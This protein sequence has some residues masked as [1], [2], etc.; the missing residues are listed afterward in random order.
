MPEPLETIVISP[1]GRHDSTVIWMH[2][3]GADGSDFLPIVPQLGLPSDN[4]IRFIFPNAPLRPITIN[5]GMTM[6]GW[7]DIV[8]LS[9]GVQPDADGIV[10]S[11][12]AIADLVQQERTAG[13]PSNRIMLAGFSQ[14]GAIALHCGP[15]YTVPLA[16]IC[17]LS[18][19]L[20][21]AD[22]LA[23]E[24]HLC[25]LDTPIFLAHGKEDPLISISAGESCRDHLQQR[26]YQVEWRAYAMAHAAFHDEL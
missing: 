3:L 6:R 26:G 5:Q 11:S 13:I 24:A 12:N 1:P 20:P 8:E 2:G 17:A 4:G 7:Y 22:R 10:A 18:C 16:G 19:Y 14:G 9:T 15:R 23:G 21:L 25:N